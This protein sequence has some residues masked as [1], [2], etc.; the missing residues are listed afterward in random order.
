MFKVKRK[1]IKANRIND[2]PG[3]LFWLVCPFRE[4]IFRKILLNLCV[5]VPEVRNIDA[6][7]KGINHKRNENIPAWLQ[8]SAENRSD[9]INL[10][11]VPRLRPKLSA[12]VRFQII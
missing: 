2:S 9:S 11:C 7:S 8:S 6:T 5:Q 10:R 1:V 3:S 4:M 12:I